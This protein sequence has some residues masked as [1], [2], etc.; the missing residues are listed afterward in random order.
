MIDRENQISTGASNDLQ[1]ATQYALSMAYQWGMTD[2][3]LRADP[4]SDNPYAPALPFY[5]QATIAANDEKI[6]K[7]LQERYAY[8]KGVLK[9]HRDQLL[10]LVSVSVRTEYHSSMCWRTKQLQV[11]MRNRRQNN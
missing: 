9:E 6:D 1:K 2:C 8:V 7:F 5:S 10:S 3:G 4:T 11:R